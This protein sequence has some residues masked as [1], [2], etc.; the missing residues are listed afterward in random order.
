MEKGKSKKF[1][2]KKFKVNMY[3]ENCGICFEKIDNK[4]D[5]VEWKYLPCKHRICVICFEKLASMICPF[6]RQAILE[7]NNFGVFTENREIRRISREAS[8]PS[9]HIDVNNDFGFYQYMCLVCMVF[10][11]TGFIGG[12]ILIILI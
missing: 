6:C 2:N 1:K 12:L 7:K 3:E 8:S 4:D 10:L 11:G 5:S 9:I